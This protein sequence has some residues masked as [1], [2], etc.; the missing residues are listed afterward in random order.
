METTEN[1]TSE[2]FAMQSKWLYLLTAVLVELDNEA[3]FGASNQLPWYSSTLL[4]ESVTIDKVSYSSQQSIENLRTSWKAVCERVLPRL[5]SAIGHP[6]EKCRDH[7]SS[8]L[9]R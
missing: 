2:G 7:I 9:F 8:C 1:G 6:Y 4:N 5:L 3:D